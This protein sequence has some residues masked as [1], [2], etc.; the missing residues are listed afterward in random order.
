M[1]L[2][3]VLTIIKNKK[4]VYCYMVIMYGTETCPRCDILEEK[5]KNSGIEYKKSLEIESLIEKGFRSVPVLEVNGEFL[6]FG[7]AVKWVKE[8]A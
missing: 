3:H 5:L 6:D 1:W 8:N 2:V 7:K 4:G